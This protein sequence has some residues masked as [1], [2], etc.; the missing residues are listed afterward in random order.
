MAFD[1]AL[2]A[3]VAPLEH[4]EQ[5]SMLIDHDGEVALRGQLAAEDDG[6]VLGER[7]P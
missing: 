5:L 6:N 1:D 2:D 3:V 7:F 4:L